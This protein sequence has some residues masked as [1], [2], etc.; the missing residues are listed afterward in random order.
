VEAA[1]AGEQGRGFAVVA[2]EVRNLAQ[3]SAAAAKEIKTLIGESVDKVDT[4]ARLVD[5][6]GKTMEEIVASVK[7]VSDLI[8]EIAAASEEQD[9][10]IQQVNS[11]VTQMDRVVQQ[12]ASLVEEATAATE[13]MKGQASSL[14]QTV[15]RFK[16]GTGVTQPAP[17]PARKPQAVVQPAA[18]APIEVRRSPKLPPVL[19]QSVGA[20]PAKAAANGEW[21]EF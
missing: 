2:A 6:A 17:Q 16:L 15:A 4:G 14:L 21:K 20:T 13:S 12:N 1:R 5:A 8:A 11:A 9:A 18:P 7:K 3:R 10:G 19:T